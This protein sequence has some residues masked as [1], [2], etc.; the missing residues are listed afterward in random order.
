MRKN[1]DAG[2][3]LPTGIDVV[4]TVVP[5]ADWRVAS[6]SHLPGYRLRVRF[7]DGTE[8]VVFMGGFI[9]SPEA[10]VFEV[11]R[12]EALFAQVAL[13]LGAVTWPGDLDLAPD[14][15]YEAIRKTGEFR[16]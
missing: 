11:L 3:D 14:A 16:P 10:G 7:N 2:K 4:P 1:T 12:D 8:G 5:A 13:H 6:V 9:N 15:M